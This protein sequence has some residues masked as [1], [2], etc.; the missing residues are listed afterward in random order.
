MLVSVAQARSN[1][2]IHTTPFYFSVIVVVRVDDI[3]CPT[4]LGPLTCCHGA[5]II[6]ASEIERK[7]IV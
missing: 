2:A 1:T 4:Q 3:R 5:C 6:K 7:T